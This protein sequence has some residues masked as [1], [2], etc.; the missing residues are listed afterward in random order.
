MPTLA[1]LTQ[2]SADKMLK[3]QAKVLE[4]LQAQ[5]GT[6][7]EQLNFSQIGKFNA[8][9][10]A[11]LT[12]KGIILNRDKHYT[13]VVP[14]LTDEQRYVL[15]NDK[16]ALMVNFPYEQF[17]FIVN[18]PGGSIEEA[19]KLMQKGIEK[20]KEMGAKYGMLGTKSWLCCNLLNLGA[21][22]IRMTLNLKL[23]TEVQYKAL[24]K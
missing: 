16:F 22:Q 14:I 11:A 12:A 20:S 18:Q 19:V 7:G 5:A 15:H 3:I 23:A 1:G 4:G 10:K 17:R 9:Q 6:E 24:Q 8:E 2:S 21:F 13:T